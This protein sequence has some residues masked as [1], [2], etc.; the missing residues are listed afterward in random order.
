MYRV[1]AVGKEGKLITL[2]VSDTANDA[3]TRLKDA[4]LD[5]PSAW[6]TDEGDM[7][8]SV[9][10]LMTLAEQEQ[11]TARSEFDASQKLKA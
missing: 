1:N 7:D 10:D 8:V 9:A 2:A 6:V 5:Y 11:R 4:S 3:L